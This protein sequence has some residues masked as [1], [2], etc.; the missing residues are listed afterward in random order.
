[1]L[2]D[3]EINKERGV[4]LSEKRASDSAGYRT[5]VARFEAML[6]TTLLPRR[7]PYRPPGGDHESAPRTLR[8]FLEHVVSAGETGRHRSWAIFPDPGKVEKMIADRFA[9]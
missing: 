5:F 4:I 8:R 6:G 1:M 9:A 3:E 7:A 2:T